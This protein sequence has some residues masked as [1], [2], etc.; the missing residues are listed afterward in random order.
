M[1]KTY[2]DLS[3]L[4]TFKER[5]E[6]LRLGGSVGKDTFGFDRYL[7]Q[8][9]YRSAS[10]KRIRDEVIIRDNGCD[11]GINGY[12]IY[13]KI[14]I[15]HINPISIQDIKTESDILLNP[16]YLITTTQ[17]THNAIHYGDASLLPQEPIQ[18]TKNDTCP[19]RH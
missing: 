17:S 14:F 1:I 7:N 11:L 19:W 13:G 9:F 8:L 5:Y 16:E 6:Y 10:W 18:R 4:K 12:E 15:H 2:S 3:A